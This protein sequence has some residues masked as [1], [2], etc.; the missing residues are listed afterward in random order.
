MSPQAHDQ[1]RKLLDLSEEACQ[2][3]TQQRILKSLAFDNMHGRFE[4]VDTAH[5]KTFR[6]IFEDGLHIK[7]GDFS[8]SED[9]DSPESEDEESPG[10]EDEH[11]C[12]SGNEDSPGGEDEHLSGSEDEMPLGRENENSPES[13]DKISLRTVKREKDLRRGRL[14][15]ESFISWLSSG[16]GIFHISGKLG[17]GKS[18]LMKF[19]CEHKHTKVELQKW[20][21]MLYSET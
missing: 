17:S 6:W 7:G 16:E 20:A 18:T 15:S 11:T 4:E 5:Y 10:G 8:G 14:A 12:G 3:I 2:I 9:E 19:L 13:E 1:L 21:G